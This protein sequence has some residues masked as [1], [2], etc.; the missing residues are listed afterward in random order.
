MSRIN[1]ATDTDLKVI[2]T[3]QKISGHAGEFHPCIP[4]E[5]YVKVS[6]HTVLHVKNHTKLVIKFD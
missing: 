2:E 6:L 4:T 5:P 3:L 1:E